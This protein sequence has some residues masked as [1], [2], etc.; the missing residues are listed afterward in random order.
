MGVEQHVQR[1]A[2]KSS[3]RMTDSPGSASRRPPIACS[4]SQGFCALPDLDTANAAAEREREAGESE[5]QERR[6]V[7]FSRSLVLLVLS[8]ARQLAGARTW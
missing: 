5:F 3:S 1:K 4:R 6:D 7:G 2:S 8:G